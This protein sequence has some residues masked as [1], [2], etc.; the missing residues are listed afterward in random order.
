MKLERASSEKPPPR[1]AFQ[2][3]GHFLISRRHAGRML[4]ARFREAETR[5]TAGTAVHTSLVRSLQDGQAGSAGETMLHRSTTRPPLHDKTQRS[6]A[7]SAQRLQSL[8]SVS[9]RPACKSVPPGNYESSRRCRAFPRRQ[10]ARAA[11]GCC[12]TVA[13][14][15]SA[16]AGRSTL[17]VRP[18]AFR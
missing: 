10:P 5:S 8:R 12:A 17:S 14:S 2:R 3:S 11:P 9:S 16:C 18:G 4:K 15:R 1:E 13:E 7:R 6:Y